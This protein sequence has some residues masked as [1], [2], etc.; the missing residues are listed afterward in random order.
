MEQNCE[1]FEGKIDTREPVPPSFLAGIFDLY[2]RVVSNCSSR[3][4]G[5]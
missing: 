4:L 2:G 3:F 5:F 1:E